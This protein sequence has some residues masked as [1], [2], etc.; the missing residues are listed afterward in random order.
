VTSFG[1]GVSKKRQS[2]EFQPATKTVASWSE[3]AA[4]FC[5]LMDD[6]ATAAAPVAIGQRLVFK[7]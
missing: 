6:A 3:R 4:I 1:I 7:K 5:R 2:E